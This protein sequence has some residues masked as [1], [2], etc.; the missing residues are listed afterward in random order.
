M[1]RGGTL[2]ARR[3]LQLGLLL[4][5]ASG[6]EELHDL[7]ELAR[8]PPPAGAGGAG[9]VRLPDHFLLAVEEAQQ[10][11]ETNR[12]L[13]PLRPRDPPR[14]TEDSTQRSGTSAVPR[15]LH[16][17]LPTHPLGVHVRVACGRALVWSMPLGPMLGLRVLRVAAIYWLLHESIY[18]DG[19]ADGAARGPS[20]W[21]A[22]RV[23]ASLGSR[24][25][26]LIGPNEP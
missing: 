11:F 10:Q 1:P 3:F 20:Q 13:P 19:N 18:C 16:S 6:F 23:Q 2:T 12:T 8:C 22:E 25:R 26:T 24:S 14:E 21:A 7:L 17:G 9:A 4:G 15:T 5:S